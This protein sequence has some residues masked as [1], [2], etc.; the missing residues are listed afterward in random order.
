MLRAENVHFYDSRDM[1]HPL[2]FFFLLS[3]IFSSLICKAQSV[4]E[5][6]QVLARIHSIRQIETATGYPA[7][8]EKQQLQHVLSSLA[9][10]DE[11]L[12]KGFIQYHPVTMDNRTQMNPTFHIQE[13]KPVSLRR[14]G[15]V[16]LTIKDPPLI[17]STSQT[18]QGGKGLQ[19]NSEVAGSLTITASVLLLKELT[20]TQQQPIGHELNSGIIFTTSA[21][22][23]GLF[24][25]EQL[26][27]KSH[28]P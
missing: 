24:I 28:R 8:L 3:C 21:L 7:R 1:Q 10:D 18:Y 19:V 23:T 4:A 15:K 26:H 12:L 14:L 17:F 27:D 13:I 22:A 16:D 5:E 9:T 25:W 11:V 20:T 2:I 6:V